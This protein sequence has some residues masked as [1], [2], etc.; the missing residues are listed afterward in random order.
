M[1]VPFI[2]LKASY[3]PLHEEIMKEMNG[4]FER[5]DFVLGGA[6]RDFEAAVREYCGVKYA[7]GVANGTDALVIA[8]RALNIGKGDEVITTPF[9][10]FATAES[11]YE[12]GARPVFCDISPESY[13]LDPK[14][15]EQF[16]EAYCDQNEKGIFNRA[17][18]GRVRAILPVHLYGLMADM[19]AFRHLQEKYGLDIIEDAAQAMGATVDIDGKEFAQAGSVGDVGCFSFYPSKNLGGSGDGGMIVTNREDIFE[20]AKALHVHGSRQRYYHSEFGYNS[21][22]D[23]IQAAVLKLKLPLM[24]KWLEMRVANAQLYNKVLREKLTAAKIPVVMS[25][26]LP[27]DGARPEGAV[28]LPSEPRCLHHTYNSYEIRVPDR[29]NASKALNEQG[30]GTMIYYPLPLH[31][32]DVF[33][34]LKLGEGDLPVAERICGDILALPQ[35]PEIGADA[36]EHVADCLAG[37]LKG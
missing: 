8:L 14:G 28:V 15:V 26:E 31:L 30:V 36:I 37:Y 23:T 6:V 12:V 9:T 29:D 2:D 20:K 17:T 24:P 21:R 34:Y 22:L 4:V 18:G 1:K 27:E 13:N 11:I 16:I 7:L 19:Q 33:E 3:N 32:Q 5:C 10:F 35:Y 25:A